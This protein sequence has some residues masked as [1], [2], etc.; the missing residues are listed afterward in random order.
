MRLPK[1]PPV[2]M[3][4]ED[5]GAMDVG[6]GLGYQGDAQDDFGAGADAL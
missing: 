6:E 5:F 1:P 2:I 4:A 3:D